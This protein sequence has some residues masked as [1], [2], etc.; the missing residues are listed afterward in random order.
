MISRNSDNLAFNK[1]KKEVEVA[2]QEILKEDYNSEKVWETQLDSEQIKLI[3]S[4][5]NFIK[6][7]KIS[8]GEVSSTDELL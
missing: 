4:K 3:L 6:T 8:Q 5:L 2:I 1:L 7:Q